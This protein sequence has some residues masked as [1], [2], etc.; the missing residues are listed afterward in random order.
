MAFLLRIIVIFCLLTSTTASAYLEPADVNALGNTPPD[1]KIAYGKNPLQYGN[2]RLPQGAGAGPFPVVVII[3][4]GCWLSSLATVQN[5]ES[6]AE[7]L[8]VQGYATWNIEYRSADD[9]GGAWPGT[10]LDV[11]AATDYLRQ[12]AQHYHLDLNHVVVIG[13]SAGGHLALWMAVRHNL[14]TNSPLYTKHPLKLSGVIALAGIPDL[15]AWQT[16]GAEVCGNDGVNALLGNEAHA[17]DARLA[18]ASPINLLPAGIPEILIFG[19]AD[20]IV[21]AEYGNGYLHAAKEKSDEVSVVL[22]H[23]AGHFELITPHSVAWDDITNALQSLSKPV[24]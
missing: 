5:T 2:L 9:E 8:R 24:H 7:A 3:H 13:H 21:S 19:S 12:L 20:N 10:F 17:R 11:A 23:D 6:L 1:K 14:S 16:H 4:G 15:A 18:D 22:V